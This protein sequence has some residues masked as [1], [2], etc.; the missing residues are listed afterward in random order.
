[1]IKIII[2]IFMLLLIIGTIKVIKENNLKCKIESYILSIILYT[3]I[4]MLL[5]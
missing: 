2:Q 1:M 5:F 4:L 3:I